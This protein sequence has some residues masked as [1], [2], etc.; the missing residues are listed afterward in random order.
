M[1]V[2]SFQ[3]CSKTRFASVESAS[4]SSTAA[5][6][7]P[8]CDP[9]N[10][11]RDYENVRCQSPN[12]GLF[13]AIQYYTVVCNENG[14]WTRN[15]RGAI[16]YS[17]CPKACENSVRPSDIENVACPAPFQNERNGVQRYDVICLSQ[18]TWS[19]TVNGGPDYSACSKVCDSAQ[20]PSDTSQVACPAPYANLNSGIQRYT[21]TCNSNGTWSRTATGGVDYS[22]CPLSCSEA[23]RP[24]SSETVK[25]PASSDIKAIQNYSVT[26]N[27]NGT[28]S[29]VPTTLDISQCPA[30]TCNPATRPGSQETVACPAPYANTILAVQNYSISCSGTQWIRTPTT[31]DESQCPK[32]CGVQPPSDSSL[33]ACQSPYQSTLLAKQN[34]F[35]V[36]N[37]QTGQYVRTVMGAVDYGAC[38]KSCTGANPATPKNVACPS[39]FTGTAVQNYSSTCNTTTGLWSTPVPTTLDTS[40][41]KPATCSGNPPSNFDPAPCPAPFQT[42][43]DAKKMYAAATCVNGSWVRGAATGVIDTSSCPVNDCTGSVNPGTEKDISAC[44][45]GATGRVFQTCSVTC[46]GNT[47]QQV[48][49]SAD[50][51]SRCDC[52]PNA[53]FNVVTR[54]CVSTATYAW[55]PNAITRGACSATACGT[56]GTQTGTYTT[57]RRND[58][59]IVANSYC[60]SNVAPSISCSAPACNYSYSAINVQYGACSA[61]ACGTSGTRPVSSF[62]C[63]R[64]DGSIVSNSYCSTPAA[65]SCSAP[66]CASYS[67]QG[68]VPVNATMCAGDNQNL[69][70]NLFNSVVKSC[71]AT[72][73]EYTCNAGTVILNGSCQTCNSTNASAWYLEANPDVKAAGMDAL[74]HWCTYGKNEGRAGCFNESQCPKSC[75]G[76][77]TDVASEPNNVGTRTTCSFSWNQASPGQNVVLT[78]A[79]NGGTLTGTCPASGTGVWQNVQATCPKPADVKVLSTG[80]HCDIGGPWGW[81]RNV[82][83]QRCPVGTNPVNPAAVGGCPAGWAQFEDK[84]CYISNRDS[85]RATEC[86]NSDPNDECCVFTCSASAPAPTWSCTRDSAWSGGGEGGDYT[87]ANTCTCQDNFGRKSTTSYVITQPATCTQYD[88]EGT[89]TNMRPEQGYCRQP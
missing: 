79:T 42:R 30:P 16:D 19:R 29:R 83:A 82:S 39:G 58:G 24:A 6:V 53:S 28:W 17:Q 12:Q 74:T 44:P 89:C 56:T 50:N 33:V 36:C 63:Q 70:S 43:M 76:G 22:L 71:T 49:C 46:T 75:A 11:L 86:L 48:N 66:A 67:C 31:R 2:V 13:L 85:R 61:T 26:C 41:C 54:T 62:Q 23:Q 38:P 21:V 14:S 72:K 20:R 80:S 57:C 4:L 5:P 15:A 84:G 25:C 69:T 87:P 60:G 3:N 81:Y 64:N 73:C 9:A 8:I 68:S 35:Y 59:V 52:G 55:D 51:Y 27:G 65:Q 37:T 7:S 88:W 34:Y 77:S 32:A 1:T 47:Y 45:G 10:R 78:R 40:A 18:G